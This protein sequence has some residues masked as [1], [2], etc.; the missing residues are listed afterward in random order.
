MWTILIIIV[1][2]IIII[3]FWGS[4]QQQKEIKDFHILNGGL[5]KSFPILTSYLE[6]TYEMT[7]AID[8]GR[9]FSY[10]KPFVD[11]NSKTGVLT[12]GVKYDSTNQLV[13]FS[14]FINTYS[15]EFKG[16][17]VTGM[18]FENIE[19]IEKSINISIDK[20]KSQG[21]LEYK[22]TKDFS[23]K[24]PQLNENI[25]FDFSLTHKQ[26]NIVLRS[27]EIERLN[28]LIDPTGI[29]AV[30]GLEPYK[31][32]ELFVYIR[33]NEE[34][35]DYVISWRYPK[36]MESDPYSIF[37]TISFLYDDEITILRKYFILKAIQS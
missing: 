1:I 15:T 13:L 33:E 9:L 24:L 4:D 18:N 37:N 22:N 7:N 26:L 14:N 23:S 28:N 16:L 11:A 8:D 21:V 6:K 36:D 32:A 25:S 35:R 34:I 27:N 31:W 30:S 2:A 12:I 20:L 10:S 3:S 19:S 5:R 17:D 29:H